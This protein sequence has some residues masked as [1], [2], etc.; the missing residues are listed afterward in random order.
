MEMLARRYKKLAFQRD[1]RMGRRNCRR[2]RY[3]NDP[4]RNNP[5]TC[6]GCKQP[7]HVRSKCPMNKKGKKDKDK[8]KKKAIVAAWFDN[9]LSS[10]ESEPIMEIKT[11]LFLMAIGDEVCL[12]E[13]DDFDKLQ[14]EYEFLFN[15]FEKLRHGC[16]TTRKSSLY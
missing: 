6:Y 9:N 16:K 11:N 4:S 2:D 14:N 5:I 13:Q 12:D 10:S 15:D 7:R 1:Q 8:K 3:Q